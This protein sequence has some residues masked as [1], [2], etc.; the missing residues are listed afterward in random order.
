[1]RFGALT[2]ACVVRWKPSNMHANVGAP[3]FRGTSLL[4]HKNQLTNSFPVARFN[5]RT[6]ACQSQPCPWPP[7]LACAELQSFERSSLRNAS[8]LLPSKRPR[9]LPHIDRP[10]TIWPCPAN[11]SHRAI[12]DEPPVSLRAHPSA[13]T[14]SAYCL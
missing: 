14:T 9:C 13:T 5:P 8:V 3:L 4:C 10:P 6:I 7:H 2:C 12:A 11:A 1:M